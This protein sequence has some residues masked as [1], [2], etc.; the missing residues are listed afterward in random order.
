MSVEALR[1]TGFSYL[2]SAV[3][4][5]EGIAQQ[6]KSAEVPLGGPRGTELSEFMQFTEELWGAMQVEHEELLERRRRKYSDYLSPLESLFAVEDAFTNGL[7]MTLKQEYRYRRKEEPETLD[8]LKDKDYLV[9]LIAGYGT[10]FDIALN[11][12]RLLGVEP[13]AGLEIAKN[14]YAFD[15]MELVKLRKEFPAVPLYVITR[16]CLFSPI[17]ASEF[18]AEIDKRYKEYRKMFDL[19]PGTIYYYLTYM[20]HKAEAKL[21]DLE[22]RV[23]EYTEEFP[24]ISR[25][26]IE[27]VARGTP[28]T[29]KLRL[30]NLDREATRLKEAFNEFPESFIVYALVNYNKP[31]EALRT[32]R[33]TLRELAAD[34]ESY[35]P[36]SLIGHVVIRH[37]QKA[38]TI[39]ENAKRTAQD[40]QKSIPEIPEAFIKRTTIYH[41]DDAKK[42]LE[43]LREERRRLMSVFPTLP[44]FLILRVVETYGNGAEKFLGKFQAERTNPQHSDIPDWVLIK[45]AVARDFSSIVQRTREVYMQISMAYPDAPDYRKWEA[46]VSYPTNWVEYMENGKLTNAKRSVLTTQYMYSAD[47]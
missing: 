47:D 19:Q 33:K 7:R 46:A 18:V 17:K 3:R 42:Y 8:Q 31:Q 38:R 30:E 13:Q 27:K 43:Y 21:R 25:S 37:P 40:L 20:P 4:T 35:F 14:A 11:S 15:A 26:D 1:S 28:K 45:A 2:R 29:A 24:N 23:R 34:F 6:A 39:L 9:G 44:A 22:Q 36:P 12:A 41:S 32:A 16:A 5:R 10:K